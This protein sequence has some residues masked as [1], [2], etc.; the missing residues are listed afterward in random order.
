MK[1]TISLLI[2]AMAIL[3]AVSCKSS[4]EIVRSQEQTAVSIDKNMVDATAPAI[5]FTIDTA[6]ISNLVLNVVVSYTGPKKGVEFKLMWNGAWLK[7]NPPKAMVY[8]EPVCSKAT[9][10]CTV[11]HSMSFDISPLKASNSEFSLLLRD[12]KQS[13]D[14]E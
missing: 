8:L 3:A 13:F 6:W 5:S 2:A 14:I 4:K 12:Y 9:G 11:K 10:N 7:M 1:P